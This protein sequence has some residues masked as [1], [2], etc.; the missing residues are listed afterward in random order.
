MAALAGEVFDWAKKA[1]PASVVH[2]AALPA[3]KKRSQPAEPSPESEGNLRLEP[4]LGFR[5]I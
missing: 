2:S 5:F 3:L 1:A 4:Q